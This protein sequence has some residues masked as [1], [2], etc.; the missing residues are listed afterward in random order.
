MKQFGTEKISIITVVYNSE[1]LIEDTILSVLNQK[2]S[3]LEYIV[4]DGASTDKTVEIL[5]KY[6]DRIEHQ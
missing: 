6:L 5:S 2:Y 4:V 3:N 1:D